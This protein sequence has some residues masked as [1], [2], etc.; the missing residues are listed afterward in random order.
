MEL[1]YTICFIRRGD[2]ILLLNR[3]SAPWM[4][5]WNGVGGKIEKNETP[6]DC[7][8]REI[9]EETGLKVSEAAYKGM[10][11][12]QAADG[13][14]AGGMYAFIVEI[15]YTITY[16]TPI[17]R[18]EGILDWKKLDWILDRDNTGIANLKYFLPLLLNDPDQ[19][20]HHFIY[21]GEKVENFKSVK[22][23]KSLT[24]K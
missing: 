9:A 1:K 7:I 16:E 19:Y 14:H 11:T 18:A 5:M 13:G 10:V 21:D 3:E 4:G 22:I 15:P 12:W 20:R 24:T 6:Q 23:E 8:L 17:K 2:S